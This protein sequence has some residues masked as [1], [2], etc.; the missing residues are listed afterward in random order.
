MTKNHHHLNHLPGM[1]VS[2]SLTVNFDRMIIKS[3]SSSYI[4][5]PAHKFPRPAHIFR[6]WLIKNENRLIK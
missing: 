5:I 6:K 2:L 4:T 1:T 3:K